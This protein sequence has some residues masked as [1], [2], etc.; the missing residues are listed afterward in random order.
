MLVLRFFL[1][2][3]KRNAHL[4]G[5]SRIRHLES[6]SSFKAV[7]QSISN[8]I[9]EDLGDPENEVLFTTQAAS[10]RP[11]VTAQASQPMVAEVGNS[12]LT[13]EINIEEFP[14]ITGDFDRVEQL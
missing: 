10:H 7:I 8:A 4:N 5:S 14:W 6:V 3:R 12:E 9:I 11:S 2:L 13:H 1:E